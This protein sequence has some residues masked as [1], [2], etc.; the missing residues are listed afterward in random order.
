MNDSSTLGRGDAAAE[1]AQHCSP[2]PKWAALIDDVVI[3][4]PQREVKA[5]A[6]L[7]Q[8]ERSRI[9]FL[10]AITVGEQDVAIAED[11][12]VNLERG[13]VFYIV[14]SC[15]RRR[16]AIAPSPRNSPYSWTTV[17]KSH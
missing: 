12:V 14:A 9:T 16:D 5:S 17:R 4:A 8:A 1:H 2:A 15:E 13:N 11:E 6:L 10:F 7:A 3:P